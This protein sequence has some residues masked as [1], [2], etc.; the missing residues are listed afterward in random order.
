MLKAYGRIDSPFFIFRREAGL[1]THNEGELGDRCPSQVLRHLRTLAEWCL[2]QHRH[3]KESHYAGIMEG[4]GKPEE[5]SVASAADNSSSSRRLVVTEL[6]SHRRF[7][8]ETGSNLSCCSPM[9]LR[10]NDYLRHLDV[11]F[12]H[13]TKYIKLFLSGS[14]QFRVGTFGEYLRLSYLSCSGRILIFSKHKYKHL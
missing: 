7:L 2:R 4:G 6:V 11:V 12:S 3:L 14:S 10:R 8:I 13:N 1:P 5:L 9:T